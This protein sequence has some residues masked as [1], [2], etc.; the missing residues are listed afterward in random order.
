MVVP[1]V[2]I[3]REMSRDD[4]IGLFGKWGSVPD[5]RGIAPI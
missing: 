5:S 2:V 3:A 4:A 1:I